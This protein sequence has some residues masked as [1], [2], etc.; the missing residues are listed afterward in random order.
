MSGAYLLNL[1]LVPY[2]EAFDLQRSLAGAV[3]RA[4]PETVIF[5]EHP[6]VVT[7]GRRTE[8]EELHIPDDAVVEIAETDRGGSRPSTGRASSSAIRSSTSQSTGRTSSST[9][10]TS[11]RLSSGL[12]AHSGSKEPRSKG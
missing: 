4:I 10:G 8:T 7:F 6:P 1:G 2:G 12:C 9:S 5:L 3:S 11:R